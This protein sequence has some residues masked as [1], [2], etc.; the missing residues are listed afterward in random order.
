MSNFVI[1]LNSMKALEEILRDNLRKIIKDRDYTQS[2]LSDCSSLSESQVS[3]YL[4]GRA[5]ISIKQLDE[6]ARGLRMRPIDIITY[7]DVYHKLDDDRSNGVQAVLQ[8]RL[9]K[10]KRDAILKN[11]LGDIEIL[12]SL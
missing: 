12:E 6:I 7:P 11:V 9:S 4:N 8:I 2:Y 5:R 10:E 3:R 1:K